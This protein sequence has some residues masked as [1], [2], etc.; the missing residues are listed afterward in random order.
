MNGPVKENKQCKRCFLTKPVSDFRKN[1]LEC[2]SCIFEIR[3]IK[4]SGDRYCTKCKL[5]KQEIEFNNYSNDCKMC[6]ANFNRNKFVILK[7]HEK[8]YSSWL[9]KHSTQSRKFYSKIIS[10]IESSS[11]NSY[12][13]FLWNTFKN[14]RKNRKRKYSFNIDFEHIIDM[15]HSQNKRCAVTGMPFNLNNY[16]LDNGQ[17]KRVFAPSIDR[18]NSGGNYTI[19]NV[20]LVCVMVNIAI[21][22]FGDKLF[23]QMCSSFINHQTKQNS[24]FTL[25][26]LKP[27]PCAE[28]GEP[29]CECDK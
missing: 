3:K 9:E 24:K 20:R 5:F 17:T 4:Y 26:D 13:I 7:S 22:N 10:E 12:N 16:T 21:N 25:A 23:E 14:A 27:V 11:D 15:F 28:H 29:Y 8:E 18:I 6:K 19:D 1:R 2:K